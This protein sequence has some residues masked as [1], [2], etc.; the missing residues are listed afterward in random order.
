MN[1]LISEPDIKPEILTYNVILK[2]KGIYILKKRLKNI[3]IYILIV[4]SRD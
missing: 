4:Y 3:E 2:S 1:F